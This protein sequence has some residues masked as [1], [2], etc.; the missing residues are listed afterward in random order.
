[1][2]TMDSFN[3]QHLRNL[4][5]TWTKTKC[6]LFHKISVEVVHPYHGTMK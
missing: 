6:V 4:S 5:K 2:N 1:M 3:T